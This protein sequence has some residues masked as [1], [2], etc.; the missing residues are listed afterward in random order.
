MAEENIIES[1]TKVD[2]KLTGIEKELEAGKVSL[3]EFRKAQ[4]QYGDEQVKLAR[5]LA[6]LQQKAAEVP[7]ES[8]NATL[9]E[10]LMKSDSFKARE[11]AGGRFVFEA[12]GAATTMLSPIAHVPALR[13]DMVAL[14]HQALTIESLLPRIPT[15]ANSVEFV[16]E[17]AFNNNAAPVAE[18]AAA[19]QSSIETEIVQVPVQAVK[20]YAKITKQLF[21]DAPAFAAFV[22]SELVYGLQL[23]TEAQILSGS[24]TA[25]NLDGIMKAGNYVAQSF[26]L[27][28]LGSA[29]VTLLDLISMSI[30]TVNA[31]GF[32]AN[33][34]IVNP[35]DWARIKLTKDASGQYLLGNPFAVGSSLGSVRVVES[36]T[37]AAGKYL[38]GDFSAAATLYDRETVTVSTAT[39][40][41]DDFVKGLYTVL[42]ERRL[43]VANRRGALG[44]LIGGNLAVPA[45]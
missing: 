43:A 17:T 20:H 45:S 42:A 12:K 28:D 37:V 14:P 26:K 9:G 35:L 5:K 4:K 29:N 30:A 22:N 15:T 18:A 44:A 1:L 25:P 33:A 6:E 19:P 7:A 2:G 39:Q 34:I 8:A 23:K 36:F 10:M 3:E 31:A 38:V 40:N 41:E 21:D 24:G 27:A 11:Q 13:A 16:R 32:S